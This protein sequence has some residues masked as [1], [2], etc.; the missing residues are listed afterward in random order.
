MNAAQRKGILGASAL[1]LLAFGGGKFWSD[2]K[3]Q[4]FASATAREKG[5]I[6]IEQYGCTE[7]HQDNN[8]FRAPL[9]KDL[10]GRTIRLQD[11]RERQADEEY[12]KKSIMDPK[13]EVRQGYQPIM[14]SYEG[15][16]GA[17]ELAFIVA[18]LRPESLQ[19]P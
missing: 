3:A 16:I 13:A 11:G 17:D 18:A 9:L 2:R 7:C 12:V 8:S 6:L 19:K 15:R 1:V 5:W 14:P 10:V 4:R